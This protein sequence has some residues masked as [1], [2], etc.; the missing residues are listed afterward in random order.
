MLVRR[1][2]VAWW[3]LIAVANRVGLVDAEMATN[4]TKYSKDPPYPTVV[5]FENS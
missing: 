4:K 3:S 5:W 2:T 1:F